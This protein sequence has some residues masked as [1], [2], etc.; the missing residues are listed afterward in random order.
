[1]TENNPNGK[2][3]VKD[4]LL[5]PNIL[6]LLRIILTPLILY[7]FISFEERG[8]PY[9]FGLLFIAIITDFFDGFLARKLNQTSALG[10]ILDPVADKVLTIT[11][12]AAVVLKRD[13]PLWAAVLIVGRDF[14]IIIA[15]MLIKRK[16]EYVPQSDIV[17]KYYFGS[18]ATMLLCYLIEFQFGMIFFF[19]STIIM[20]VLSSLNYG[21]VFRYLMKDK[22]L[23]RF[24]A[25]PAVTLVLRVVT[26]SGLAINL[27]YLYLEKI[28]DLFL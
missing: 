3:N 22:E 16:R 28:K 2:I 9:A 25:R 12:I 26:I 21:I 6:S 7:V 10:L 18:T 5:I 27:Y 20:F 23:P 8:L 13:F 14:V 1:M 24:F 17:G 19:Y 15:G 4:F 11:L